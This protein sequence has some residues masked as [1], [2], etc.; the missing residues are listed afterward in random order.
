MLQERKIPI[1]VKIESEENTSIGNPHT[2]RYISFVLENLSLT[3]LLIF[4][5]DL[6]QYMA[7]H[8]TA[9]YVK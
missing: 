3:S 7:R 6:L 9:R 5:F 8:S 1:D 2:L 4:P